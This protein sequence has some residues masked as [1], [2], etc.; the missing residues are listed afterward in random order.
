MERNNERGFSLVELLVVIGII[1][2]VA[3]ISAVNMQT[4]L[5]A[6]R[7]DTAYDMVLGQ[8]RAARQRSISERRVYRVTLTQ[9]ALTAGTITTDLM[10]AN[11]PG[12]AYNPPIGQGTVALPYDMRFA[13]VSGI[14]TSS[15]TVPDGF[16]TGSTAIDMDQTWT[17]GGTQLYFQPDGSAQDNLCRPA[18]GVVYVAR[19]GQLQTSRAITVYGTTGRIKGYRL[20]VSGGVASWQ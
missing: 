18:S 20:V 10:P 16:G 7:V 9:P 3:A 17:S 6:G 8:L 13:V 15:T 4:S 11:P 14:P 19:P 2:I 1:M 5:A 12:C